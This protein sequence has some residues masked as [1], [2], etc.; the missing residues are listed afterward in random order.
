MSGIRPQSVIRHGLCCRSYDSDTLDVA[1]VFHSNGY[2][3][4]DKFEQWV[5][6]ALSK[7]A[8]GTSKKLQ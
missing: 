4:A 1:T 5:L 6:N 2:L 3:N 7:K 8:Q